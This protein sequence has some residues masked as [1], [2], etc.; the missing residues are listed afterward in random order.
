MD[1]SSQQSQ[2]SQQVESVTVPGESAGASP[3]LGTEPDWIVGF[4]RLLDCLMHDDDERCEACSDDT[5]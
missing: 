5:L 3:A 2:V 1:T 4:K